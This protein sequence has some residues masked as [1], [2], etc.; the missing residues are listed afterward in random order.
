MIRSLTGVL[1]A[2]L[3]SAACLNP[4]PRTNST[5]LPMECMGTNEGNACLKL[6]YASTDGARNHTDMAHLVGP[7]HWAAYRG[8]DVGVC[9]PGDHPPVFHGDTTM[10]IDFSGTAP[11]V[12]TIPDAPAIAYQVL[13]FVGQE[14]ADK[15]AVPGD[16]VTF[17]SGSFPVPADKL[18]TIDV[19]INYVRPDIAPCG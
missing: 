9:G 6:S 14:S 10:A 18:T 13:G 16:P 1:I 12:I 7:L 11:F 17:P 15:K 5:N 2:G 4:A 8:G 3:V 19:E